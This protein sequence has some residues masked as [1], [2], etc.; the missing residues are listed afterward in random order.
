MRLGQ[1]QTHTFVAGI[2]GRPLIGSQ[3]VVTTAGQL[4]ILASSAR[5][6]RDIENIGDRSRGLV[7]LRPVTFRYKGDPQRARQ[8]GLMAEEVAKV[9]PELGARGTDGGGGSVQDR[10]RDPA[11]PTG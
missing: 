4:G 1:G 7:Q 9:Y 5:F 6:K 8:Y 10:A 2:A 11:V 3:V